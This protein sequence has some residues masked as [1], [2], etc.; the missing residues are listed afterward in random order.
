VLKKGVKVPKWLMA[1]SD[2]LGYRNQAQ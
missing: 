1:L 2:F